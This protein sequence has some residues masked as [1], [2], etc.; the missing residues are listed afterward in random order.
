ME[1]RNRNLVALGC[2]QGFLGSSLGWLFAAKKAG[3]FRIAMGVGP[4]HM[5]GFDLLT[6]MVVFLLIMGGLLVITY[7]A[8]QKLATN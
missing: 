3:G 8:R 6:I 7:L 5:A 2:V 4:G 1:D